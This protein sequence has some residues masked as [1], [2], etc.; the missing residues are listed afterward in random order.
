VWLLAALVVL[1]G[2]LLLRPWA[3]SRGSAR[4]EA[5]GV[6]LPD[7]PSA[8]EQALLAQVASAASSDPTPVRLLGDYYMDSAR[9]FG[10]LWAYAVA[11]RA[12]PE[13]VDATLG[14][15]RALE[16]ALLHDEATARLREVLAHK[17]GEL[18]AVVQLAELYLRT[19]RPDA[20]RSVIRDAGAAF[21]SSTDGAVLE[22]RVL[23][24]LGDAKG[25]TEA[26]RRAIGQDGKDAGA[27]HRLGLLALSQ[28]DLFNARQNLGA[29]S[30]LSPSNPRYEIDLGRTYALSPKPE[31]WDT[32]ARH[33]LSAVKRSPRFA[34]AYYEAG[35]WYNRHKRW[36]QAA[37]RLEAAVS[38][39][40]GH[41]AAHEEL[42]R[43]LEALGRRAEAH[44]HRGM[45]FAARDLRMA[46]L[47]EFQAWAALDRDN[48]Q[49][50][51]EVAQSYF[52]TQH[53]DQA[54]ARMAKARERF[55][56]E[57]AVRERLIAY[58]LVE[59]D[60]VQARRLCEEWLREEPGSPQ[61]LYLLGRVAA[62]EQQTGEAIRI[63]EQVL[64]KEPENPQWLGTLGE[65]LLKQPGTEAV[66]RAVALLARAASG[67]P[68][69]P[70]WRLLLAQGLQR[71]GRIEEARR[72]ALRALDLD[73]HQSAAYTLVVQLA[74]QEGAA[75]PLALYADLVRAVEGRLREEMPFW[76][77][78]W[79]RPRDPQAYTA[80]AGFL[81]RTGNLEKAESQLAE[82]LRLRPGSPEVRARL[83]LVRR[84]RTAL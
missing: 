33:Y 36:Q 79:K 83:E 39:D 19:G 49:A 37:E 68:E 43:A 71:L 10:A 42:A 31:E 1:G 76:Q 29:A 18:R 15:A 35:V 46:A 16:Q 50:E 81:I 22:G 54:Q 75:G 11:L 5:G 59:G 62:D 77:A 44:Q 41:A 73:P 61:I 64:A 9:P 17:P 4:P 12:R 8:K 57:P 30:I 48:P 52:E 40:P 51:I 23:Q 45:A 55:P 24:A 27:F 63:F 14:L 69:E 60:R 80:L 56:R 7:P 38:H 26:Y 82:A 25:A 66:P 70:R 32:A 28:G 74:R 6:S 21:T 65:A 3:S 78:T 84:V 13:E 58:Y 34:P 72:Q 20:A 53:A 2:V 67:S 47:R